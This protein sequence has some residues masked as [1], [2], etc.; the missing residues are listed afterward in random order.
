MT[1]ASKVP[2]TINIDKRMQ[3]DVVSPIDECD[4]MLLSKSTVPHGELYL[5]AM[6]LGWDKGMNPEIDKPSSGG[7][8]RSESFSPKL[9]TLINAIHYAVVGFESPDSLRDHKA[10][11]KLAEQYA[12]GGFH[13][14]EGELSGKA[15]TE[16]TAND[17]IAEMNEKWQSWFG[18]KA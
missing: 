7:F 2:T 5:Y 3:D 6:A 8:I 13:L 16:V 1:E 4:Y 9:T 12:N 17:L 14:L 18:E 10:A 15:D 11:F